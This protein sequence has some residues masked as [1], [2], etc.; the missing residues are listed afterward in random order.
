MV[1][2]DTVQLYCHE[3]PL[4]NQRNPQKMIISLCLMLIFYSILAT[5]V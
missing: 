2:Y 4:F 3:C 1:L 5:E